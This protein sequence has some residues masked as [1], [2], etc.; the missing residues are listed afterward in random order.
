MLGKQETEPQLK[1]AAPALT[2]PVQFEPNLA[3]LLKSDQ[4]FKSDLYKTS[5]AGLAVSVEQPP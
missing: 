4:K 3:V 5:Q 2:G 1:V